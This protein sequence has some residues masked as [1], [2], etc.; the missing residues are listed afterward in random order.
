MNSMLFLIQNF[1]KEFLD[2]TRTNDKVHDINI[3]KQSLINH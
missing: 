2:E 3:K 1:A